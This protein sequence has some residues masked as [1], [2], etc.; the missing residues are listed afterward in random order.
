MGSVLREGDTSWYIG[1]ADRGALLIDGA[2]YFATLREALLRAERSIFIIGWDIR[3]NLLLDPGRDDRPLRDLLLSVVQARPELQ[4]RILI[5]DWVLFYSLDREVLPQLKFGRHRRLQMVLDGNHPPAACHHEKLV[6]I[7]GRVAFCGG[8]DLTAGRWDLPTH[9]AREPWRDWPDARPWPPCHDCMLMVEGEVAARL[10]ALARERWYRATGRRI[11]PAEVDGA[12]TAWPEATESWFVNGRVAIARTR[13]R[14]R[15]QAPVREIAALYREAI[16]S[17]E[18]QIYIENQY[19]TVPSIGA[20]LA[21]RL[22]AEDGPEVIIVTPRH[23]E[24]V[25]ETAVMDV[26]RARLVRR[27]RRADRFGRLRMV[28][29]LAPGETVINL[30]SKLMVIDDRL[31]LVGSANLANRSM[32]LDSECVLAVEAQDDASRGAVRR[33]RET[34]LAEHLGCPVETLRAAIEERGSVVAAMDQLNGGPRRLEPIQLEPPDLP[35]EIEGAVSLFD[36]PEP[37]TPELIERHLMPPATRRRLRRVLLRSALMLTTL[38]LMAVLAK[39]GL[40]GEGGTVDRVLALA[41]PYRLSPIGF[42]LVV[43]AFILASALF[44]PINL[45]IAAT[46]AMF[47]PMIGFFYALAGALIS[48]ALA[49]ALG[50]LLGRDLVRRFAGR[51]VNAVNRRLER[52]G[53]WAVILVRVVPVAPFPVVNMV[54]GSSEVSWQ[55]FLL[56]SLIGM[57]PGIVLMTVIGDRLGA[58][59]EDPDVINFAILAV[60]TLAAFALALALR[61]WSR[62]RARR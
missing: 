52:H 2:A 12:E 29:A 39:T 62:R 32:G 50:R 17:A 53:L 56:G 58:W 15:D 54:A 6:V 55:Q 41:E 23:C 30:H 1:G 33:A 25:V 45:V 24:G 61:G 43:A 7:D 38:L 3:S 9:P 49:F 47:G 51:R 34:L 20:V 10:D 18:W 16:R 35:P 21:E 60:L 22:A 48:A 37:I 31:L 4:V 13:P 44:V 59:L 36:A 28:Y 46:G 57:A 42:A 5:W 8:I 14:H 11:E 19:F 26:G 27:L 40:A